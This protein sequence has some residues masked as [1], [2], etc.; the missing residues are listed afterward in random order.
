M[1]VWEYTAPFESVTVWKM[2]QHD[3]APGHFMIEV[4]GDCALSAEK[5]A[6][7]SAAVAA[8]NK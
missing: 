5:F 7:M 1:K 2:D 4:T 3:A 6:E 8:A